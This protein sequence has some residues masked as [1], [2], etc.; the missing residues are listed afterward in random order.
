MPAYVILLFYMGV[1]ID[2]GG[3]PIGWLPAY[4]IPVYT[5]TCLPLL[6]SGQAFVMPTAG[7]A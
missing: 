6:A 4:S 2:K 7:A 1:W 3:G 5:Q